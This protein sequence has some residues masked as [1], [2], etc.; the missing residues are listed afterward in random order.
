MQSDIYEGYYIPKGLF[1]VFVSSTRSTERYT[2]GSGGRKCLVGLSSTCEGCSKVAHH[3]D[4]A[5]SRDEARYPNGDSFIPERFLDAEGMLTDDDPAD[6]VFGFGRRRCPGRSLRPKHGPSAHNPLSLPVTA[7][8][9]SDASTWT[10]IAT[11]LATLDF[12]LAKDADG[13]DITFEAV[14]VNGATE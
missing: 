12:N 1:Y 9:P 13:N 10:A 4:R 3:L 2:R 14:F 8:Y 11:M 6:F 7:R 5:M